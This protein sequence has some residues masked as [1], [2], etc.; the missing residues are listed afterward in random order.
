MTFET[1]QGKVA[2]RVGRARR[3]RRRLRGTRA[4][5]RVRRADR[6]PGLPRLRLQGACHPAAAVTSRSI[7][8][9]A[10]LA[11]R[12]VD[13][14]RAAEPGP[15][16][17]LHSSGPP[18]SASFAS[19]PGGDRGALRD[20]LPGPDPARAEPGRRLPAQPGR[21]A[22]HG[23]AAGPWQYDGEAL[24]GD[25]A[26]AIVPFYGQGA[27][28]AFEDVVE[29]DRCLD[30]CAD[31]WSDALPLFQ[32]RRRQRRGDRADGAGELRGDAGQGGLAGVPGRQADR[33]RPGTAG[34]PAGTFPATSWSPSPPPRT[35][36]SS[37]GSPAVPG[38]R[39]GGRG[40][41]RRCWSARSEGRGSARGRRGDA[42]GTRLM[43][44][45]APVGP[46]L[47]RNFVGGEFVDAGPR[48]PSGAR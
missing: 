38:A 12:H 10:H 29:L 35:P 26:H 5:A 20:A 18:R 42:L 41:R 6:E 32:Q 34:C 37:A 48:S 33:A 16:L 7:R 44:G 28:C 25:A 19:Q 27:N 1:P 21:G 46:G 31:A 45:H 15:L 40:R 36:R 8:G 2:D 13:D 9:A 24:L 43:A 23:H 22:R 11:A 39:R 17:H 30:E 4:A 47:L 3:R 14:D